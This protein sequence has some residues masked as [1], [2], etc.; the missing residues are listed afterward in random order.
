MAKNWT[1]DQALVSAISQNLYDALPLL[2]K[3]LVR[4]EAITRE[5]GMPF[6]HIQILCMLTDRE[7]S[8]G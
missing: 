8:I 6:S 4:V 7:M 2:P 3:R 5:F 1:A